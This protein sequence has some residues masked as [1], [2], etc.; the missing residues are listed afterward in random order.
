MK[1]SRRESFRDIPIG[2]REELSMKEEHS[3][4]QKHSEGREPSLFSIVSLNSLESQLAENQPKA[5]RSNEH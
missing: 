3:T 4:F 1:I 2:Q 5:H